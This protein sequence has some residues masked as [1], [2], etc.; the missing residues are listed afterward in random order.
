MLGH[1]L[2]SVSS[3]AHQPIPVC[4]LPFTCQ[5]NFHVV[6]L[7]NFVVINSSKEMKCI[8]KP[9]YWCGSLSFCNQNSLLI[10]GKSK[11]Q[12]NE[13]KL[14]DNSFVCLE[15]QYMCEKAQLGKWLVNSILMAFLCQVDSGIRQVS[16]KSE[17]L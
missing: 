8:W 13:L 12:F 15:M 7:N 2:F 3:G 14:Q 4:K 10:D 16:A 5:V 1:L 6:V 17:G 9:N 11:S